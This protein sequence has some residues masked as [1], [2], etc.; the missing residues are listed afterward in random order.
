MVADL[1]PDAL[2]L[3][4]QLRWVPQQALHPEDSLLEFCILSNMALQLHLAGSCRS[5]RWLSGLQLGQ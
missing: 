5:M 4:H 2:H 3:I 1:L